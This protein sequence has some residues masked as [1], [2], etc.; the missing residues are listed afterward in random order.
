MNILQISILVLLITISG[1]SSRQ[2]A[3]ATCDFV[4][5]AAESEHDRKVE[6]NLR[7]R[8]HEA[9]NDDILNGLF[10]ILFGTLDRSMPSNEKSTK[11]T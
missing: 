6:N 3:N 5:G 8:K 1:C 10:S 9:D 4:Y 7:G 2:T 11:C